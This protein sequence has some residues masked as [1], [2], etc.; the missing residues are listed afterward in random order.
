VRRTLLYLGL[1]REP[2]DSQAFSQQERVR[3]AVVAGFTFG[4]I[5]LVLG[6]LLWHRSALKALVGGLLAGLLMGAFLYV[7]MAPRWRRQ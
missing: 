1:I 3:F 7:F 6:L 5:L 2:G 4:A